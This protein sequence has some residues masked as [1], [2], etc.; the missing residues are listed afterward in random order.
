M[1]VRVYKDNL[2][3]NIF[4]SLLFT[5]IVIFVLAGVAVA[6]IIYAMFSLM[7]PH[8]NWGFYLGTTAFLEIVFYACAT[9]K[10]DNQPIFKIVSRA[11]PF[12]FSKKKFRA[13]QVDPYFRDF[14]IQDDLIIRNKSISK[15][16]EIKPFDISAIN[17]LDRQNFFSNVKM[18]L[19]TLPYQ[20]QI[21]IR[22]EI[23]TVN[24]FTDHF[25]YLYK[26]VRKGDKRRETM[27]ANYQK[28]LTEFIQ[29]EQVLTIKQYGV[30][31]TKVD[32]VNPKEK[33]QA[34]GKLTDMY[35][36]LKT[37]LEPCK[38]QTRQLTNTEIEKQI[39]RVLR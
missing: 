21:I 9:L 5:D 32:T 20:L 17:V 14:T 34:I 6:I 16:F 37:S 4:R 39:G 1:N 19:H 28:D 27:I 8:F 22:K 10:I 35:I 26:S 36:R 18:A 3:E 23:A 38:I 11:V 2:R 29:N 12:T 31:S 24:D 15:I 7:L 25:M 13:Y 30:F 33:V